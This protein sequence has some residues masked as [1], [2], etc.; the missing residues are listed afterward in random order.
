MLCSICIL[1]QINAPFCT[2]VFDFPLDFMLNTEVPCPQNWYTDHYVDLKYSLH[3]EISY[4]R[5][6]D[7][8]NAS[9]AH[10]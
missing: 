7:L 3:A 2:S 10:I 9:V 6:F 4:S 5:M 8:L 1:K